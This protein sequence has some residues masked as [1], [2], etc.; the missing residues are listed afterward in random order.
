MTPPP[1]GMWQPDS[2]CCIAHVLPVTTPLTRLTHTHTHPFVSGKQLLVEGAFPSFI[3]KQ[4]V[5]EGRLL[6]IST[7]QA[8][9]QKPL[10]DVPTWRRRDQ[11]FYY[12]YA[13]IPD[14]SPPPAS[15]SLHQPFKVHPS[16]CCCFS[17]HKVSPPPN[18]ASP[19]FPLLVADAVKIFLPMFCFLRKRPIM[20]GCCYRLG[21]PF[22]RE[23]SYS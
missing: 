11:G 19:L 7:Q 12:Y 22:S 8:L 5:F 20:W 6:S 3:I 16:C 14:K 2:Y 18:L 10:I 21:P 15:A 9:S 4:H 1:P 17:K 23:L 13:Y